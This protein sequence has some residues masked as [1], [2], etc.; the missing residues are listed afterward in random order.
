MGY[1][2]HITR[3][4]NWANPQGTFITPEE[5]VAVI[6]NDPELTVTGQNGPYH[7]DWSGP[8]KYPCWLDYD[9]GELFTKYPT[10]EMIEKMLVIAHRLDARVVGDE[11]EEYLGGGRVAVEEREG[12]VVRDLGGG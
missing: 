1:D 6:Q 4:Q 2:L 9:R 5:W 10:N 8:G 7:A 3:K 11:D 12:W